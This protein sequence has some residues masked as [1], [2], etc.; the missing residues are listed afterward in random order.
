VKRGL[1]VLVLGACVPALGSTEA[2]VSSPRILAVRADP[3]EARPGSSVT[4]T[5]LVAGP[6]GT[7]VEAPIAWSFCTAPKPLTEDS[8]V[9]GACLGDPSSV[10]A[11]DGAS[12][13]A[14]LPADGCSRFG[15]FAPPGGARPRDP[16]V[17]GG[18]YQPLRAALTGSAATFALL[19]ITC[20]L[21]SAPA[22]SA[23]AFAA[24]Y[25]PNE[26]PQLLAVTATLDGTP[27]SLASVPAGA[28]VE[29]TASWPAGSAETYAFYD[30]PSDTVVSKRESMS[31]SWH[32]SAGALDTEATGRAED[33]PE[34]SSSNAWTAPNAGTAH[35]WIVLRDSRGG[36][37]Y[38]SYEAS[39]VQP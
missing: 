5:A 13:T 8:V 39:V 9:S 31:L 15:P 34:T 12:F 10:P 7:V 18:Y 11:G 23:A 33:D 6:G 14:V 1:F 32:A 2:I 37:D 3:A 29:L 36:V 19:R 27:V 16:D 38:A 4:V 28:R 21:A 24:A 22:A 17:T 35:L 30:A 26:N 20:D 25:R